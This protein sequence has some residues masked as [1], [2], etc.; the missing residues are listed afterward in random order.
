MG[1]LTVLRVH[2]PDSEKIKMPILV[3]NQFWIFLYVALLL[4]MIRK[5]SGGA[6]K[7]L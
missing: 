2:S 4:K 1:I 3:Y 5:T 6:P 7:A